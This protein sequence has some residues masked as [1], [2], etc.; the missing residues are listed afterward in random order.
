[1]NFN[2]NLSCFFCRCVVYCSTPGYM[3]EVLGVGMVSFSLSIA[4]FV[5]GWIAPRRHSTHENPGARYICPAHFF[6]KSL[7]Q[8]HHLWLSIGHQSQ[9]LK[10]FAQG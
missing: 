8:S 3:K 10:A 1:M 2:F 4:I 9:L 6:S 5:L 7:P